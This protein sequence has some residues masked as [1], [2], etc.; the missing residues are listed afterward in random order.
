M[1]HTHTVTQ[2]ASCLS[3]FAD[4]DVFAHDGQA[5]ATRVGCQ[6]KVT[7][8]AAAWISHRGIYSN[9]LTR[10]NAGPEVH[11]VS[12]VYTIAV[13]AAVMRVDER[14]QPGDVFRAVSVRH[15]WCVAL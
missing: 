8:Q 1:C 12:E 14:A 2:T 5:E 4:H 11:A 10:G 6:L 15:R 7:R 9:R 13:V 3:G